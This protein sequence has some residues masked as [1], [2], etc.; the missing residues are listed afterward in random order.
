MDPAVGMRPQRAFPVGMLNLADSALPW[1]V[2]LLGEE[3]AHKSFRGVA[4]CRASAGPESD[5]QQ[6]LG[7]PNSE[8]LLAG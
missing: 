3:R 6:R 4:E 1:P 2:V 5:R 7:S 8:R